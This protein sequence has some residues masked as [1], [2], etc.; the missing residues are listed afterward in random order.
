[1]LKTKYKTLFVSDIHLGTKASQTT[2]FLEFLKTIDC[3]KIYL[4]GDIIDG[5]SMSRTKYWSQQHNDTIQKLLRQARKG[6]EIVYIPGNHDEF[7]R[8]FCDKSFRFGNIRLVDDDIH[9]TSSGKKYL[10]I[11]GDQFDTIIRNAKWVTKLGSWAYE[12]SI[13]LNI[14]VNFIRKI[15]GLPFW[16]LSSWVK[17]K[18]KKA[19]NFIGAYEETLSN[20]AKYRGVDGVICGHI[21][22]PNITM[23]NGVE[24]L[25]CGDWVE[26][27]SAIVETL[28][29]NFELIKWKQ[30]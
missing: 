22:H 25:N 12:M 29:G 18:V 5:W 11:H 8:H 20:Y 7:L 14:A 21:H 1:M 4:V 15:F 2:Q 9:I 24:Y 26:S 6:T 23:I 30:S 28:D 16:S 27:C 19:V 13:N 17:Y 3:D 10:I